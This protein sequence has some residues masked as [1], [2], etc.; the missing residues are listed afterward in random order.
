ML[1]EF[2]S[3]FFSS[4]G[5]RK[6]RFFILLKRN[7]EIL[8]GKIYIIFTVTG[9]C[10]ADMKMKIQLECVCKERKRDSP[11]I[12]KSFSVHLL[13]RFCGKDNGQMM[14]DTRVTLNLIRQIFEVAI[15]DS[16]IQNLRSF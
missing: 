1:D 3:I 6:R 12:C 14:A 9:N 16:S 15:S 5:K 13:R 7:S 11:E 10:T 4:N 8:N 2:S